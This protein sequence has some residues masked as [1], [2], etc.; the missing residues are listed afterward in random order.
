MSDRDNKLTPATENDLKIAISFALQ[1]D[2]RKPY[3]QSDEVMAAIVAEHV[4]K[5][6][7]RSFVVMQR[8]EEL[9]ASDQYPKP[10]DRDSRS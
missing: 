3:R 4:A 7:A 8:P 9:R 2:G 10:K 5:Y 1:F 6:L